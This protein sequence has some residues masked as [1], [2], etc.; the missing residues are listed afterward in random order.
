[1]IFL[2]VNWPGSVILTNN[3]DY[4]NTGGLE[5]TRYYAQTITQGGFVNSDGANQPTVFAQECDPVIQQSAIWSECQSGN[6]VSNDYPAIV[7]TLIQDSAFGGHSG[8][9][10]GRVIFEEPPLSSV[11]AIHIIT[12]ADSNPAKTLASPMHRP[13]WDAADSYIGY[14]QPT[15]EFTNSTQLSIGA[16]VSISLYI[17]NPGDG[18]NWLERLSSS[19]KS[20]KVPVIAPGFQTSSN[21]SSSAGSCG[22]APAGMIAIAP[23]TTSVTVLTTAVTTMSEIHIDENF[24]YGPALGVTCDKTLGPRYAIS[25]QTSGIS[26]VVTTDT[27]P[28]NWACLS[29][30]VT[31]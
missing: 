24:T 27:A 16:P 13:S 18:T 14:D 5:P 15:G 17:D 6:A 7:G 22:S 31:N 8:G 11:P 21:C 4:Q 28:T 3:K 26:F 12:L 30:T 23:G 20:F 1:L 2:Y 29:Y 25:E 9:L 10:K 19:L